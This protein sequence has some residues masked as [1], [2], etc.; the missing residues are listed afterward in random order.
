MMRAIFPAIALLAASAPALAQGA[1]PEAGALVYGLKRICGWHI[2]GTSLVD[3]FKSENKLNG[4]TERNVGGR[5]S[6]DKSGDWG[7][8]KVIYGGTDG[9]SRCSVAITPA[10]TATLDVDAMRAAVASFLAERFPEAKLE[11]DR[12][13]ATANT[14]VLESVWT[15]GRFTIRLGEMP[16]AA[17]RPILQVYWDRSS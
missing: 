13:P 8:I 12:A 2:E 6:Y 16:A 14:Q 1:A 5:M 3:H 15:V 10:D 17:R 9:R 11:K 7:A 4:W